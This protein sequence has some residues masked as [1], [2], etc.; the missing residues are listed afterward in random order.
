MKVCLDINR[1]SHG[2]TWRSSWEL[3]LPTGRLDAYVRL[4]IFLSLQHENEQDYYADCDANPRDPVN[5]RKFGIY[6]LNKSPN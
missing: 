2:R 6:F 5:P 3:E 4:V 1:P